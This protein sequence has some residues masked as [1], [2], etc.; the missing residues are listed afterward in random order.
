MQKLFLFV[1]VALLIVLSFFV[2]F[3]SGKGETGNDSNLLT[4]VIETASRP[5]EKYSIK[6]LTAVQIPVGNLTILSTFDTGLKDAN[7]DSYII[8]FEF[9]PDLNPK[10]R[11]KTT[12]LLNI[13]KDI[14]YPPLI[15]MIRGYVD[16]T[17]YTTGVGT[18]NA[19]FYFAEQGFAT[20]ALDYLGYAESDSEAGDIFESRFQTYT[21]TLSL[22]KTLENITIP[23]SRGITKTSAD[24]EPLMIWAHSNGGQ[25]ALTILAITQKDIPTVLWAPVTKPFPYSVLY[26]TDE[27][28]DGGKLI[29]KHL[30][31]FE[32]LYDVNEYSFTNYLPQITAPILLQQGISDDAVPWEWSTA[33][34]NKLTALEKD[35]TYIGYPGADHNMRPSWDEAIEEDAKFYKK[36]LQNNF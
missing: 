3:K 35:V 8:E 28:T 15:L 19:G 12:G 7:F 5:L 16:E 29:R 6:N 18:K 22:I 14:S 31:D 26:Y 9:S 34:A 23:T 25:I 33:F 13:P 2:G 10:F 20:I 32:T 1:L 30:A 21:A 27:S 36:Y 17:I 11:K 4:E 24:K